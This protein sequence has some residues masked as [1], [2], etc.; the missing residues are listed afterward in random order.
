MLTVLAAPAAAKPGN[1]DKP[2]KPGPLL[3]FSVEPWAEYQP[4]FSM[5]VADVGVDVEHAGKGSLVVFEASRN[6]AELGQVL[7]QHTEEMLRGGLDGLLF[8]YEF[9]CDSEIK[10]DVTHVATL[11]DRK[12]K[13]LVSTTETRLMDFSICE[14]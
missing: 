10:L 12:G 2:K 1:S 9:P 8:S 6:D 5:C 11:Y 7:L 4:D 3:T 13:E 14:P